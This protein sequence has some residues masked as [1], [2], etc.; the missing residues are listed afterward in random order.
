MMR[1]RVD[2]TEKATH[3]NRPECRRRSIWRAL[4][5]ETQGARGGG[6]CGKTLKAE[7]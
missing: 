2:E 5:K 6:K 1:L 7:G 3:P 4:I